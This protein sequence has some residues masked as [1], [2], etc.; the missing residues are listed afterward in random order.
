VTIVPSLALEIKIHRKC[1]ELFLALFLV[2]SDIVE[3]HLARLTASF[4]DYPNAQQLT[5]ETIRMT[6]ILI[7]TAFTSSQYQRRENH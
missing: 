6:L 2:L 5:S 1:V 7:S 4:A 3:P